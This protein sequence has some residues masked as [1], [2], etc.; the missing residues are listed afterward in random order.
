MGKRVA[1]INPII[2]SRANRHLVE[3]AIPVIKQAVDSTESPWKPKNRG[4]PQ[5]YATKMIVC[6]L[7][8]GAM[9]NLTYDKM[10]SVLNTNS[11]VQKEFGSKLPSHSTYHRAAKR[12]SM[13]YIQ[14]LNT[15]LVE[16]R[17]IS[18]RTVLHAD[19][20]GFRLKKSSTWF[21]I[22]VKRKNKRKDHLKLHFVVVHK[23]GLICSFVV[24]RAY[25]NDTSIFQRLIARI[26]LTHFIIC[27]DSGYLSRINCKL[28]GKKKGLAFFKPKKNTTAKSKGVKAWYDMIMLFKQMPWGF[29]LVYHLRVYIESIVGAIKQRFDHQLYSRHWFMQRRELGLKVIAHNVKQLLYIQESE[30]SNLPLWTYVD[31]VKGG[32][33][34]NTLDTFLEYCF[35]RNH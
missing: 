1:R 28:V 11:I 35:A 23:L 30:V 9:L 6:L 32:S 33:K 14:S 2:E 12:L 15:A 19:S 20:T 31:P 3:R 18:K 27:G 22:R 10:E 13:A 17:L 26:S 16:R 8:L 5:K 34:Q 4:R 21:D 7:V 29:L 25:R 24:T